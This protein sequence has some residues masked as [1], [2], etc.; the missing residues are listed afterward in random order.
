MGSGTQQITG[1]PV[2]RSPSADALPAS[3]RIVAG[4]FRLDYEAGSGGMGTVYRAVDLVSGA[5]AAV[6]ILNGRDLRDR[7][8]FEQEAA[9]LAELSHPAI[10]RYYA[11][12]IS[13]TGFAFLAMEWLEGEDLAALISRQTLATIDALFV[14]RRAAEA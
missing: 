3:A 12:G 13:E 9:I 7:R 1:P 14:I 4:R 10:V 5:V 2:V 6:K 11:H 8:R